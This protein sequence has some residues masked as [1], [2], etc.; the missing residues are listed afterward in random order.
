MICLSASVKVINLRPVAN[1]SQ[2]C[3]INYEK[4]TIIGIILLDKHGKSLYDK[5]DKQLIIHE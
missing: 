2:I 4:P 5:Y 3:N 1:I